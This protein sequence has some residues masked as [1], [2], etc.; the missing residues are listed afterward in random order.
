MKQRMIQ[1]IIK[2]RPVHP[3]QIRRP[4][5]K[6]HP[7]QHGIKIRNHL[8]AL[9]QIRLK[10]L[11]EIVLRRKFTD[12]RLI[13]QLLKRSAELVCEKIRGKI[14]DLPRRKDQ[15]TAFLIP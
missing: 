3:V 13:A 12:I 11:I 7:R 9:P 2:K 6:H 8:I 4:I 14:T 5:L 10:L 15:N 1:N